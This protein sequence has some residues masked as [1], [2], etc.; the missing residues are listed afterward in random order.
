MHLCSCDEKTNFGWRNISVKKLLIEKNFFFLEFQTVKSLNWPDCAS[1]EKLPLYFGLTSY[2]FHWS[3]DWGNWLWVINKNL[4][5]EKRI[6]VFFSFL[7]W[8]NGYALAELR[9]RYFTS[10]WTDQ[11]L[12]RIGSGFD[13]RFRI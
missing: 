11:N 12:W 1:S 6:K 5:L 2:C 9:V 10:L 4:F 13:T 3:K 7:A 8:V